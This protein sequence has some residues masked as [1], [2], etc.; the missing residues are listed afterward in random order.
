MLDEVA[1]NR[2]AYDAVFIGAGGAG[3]RFGRIDRAALEVTNDAGSV[4]F[5]TTIN[6]DI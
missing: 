5:I 4:D 2:G 3:Q 6:P 1:N